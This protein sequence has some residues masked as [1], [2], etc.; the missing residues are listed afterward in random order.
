M[1]APDAS[2]W[3]IATQF[4]P[5][6]ALYFQGNR[7]TAAI[8]FRLQLA[9]FLATKK[10]EPDARLKLILFD[11]ILIVASHPRRVGKAYFSSV[12]PA[13]ADRGGAPEFQERKG[14]HGNDRDR[15]DQ[16]QS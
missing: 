1:R 13:L 11:C 4:A 8:S 7:C 3:R 14:A 2:R 12:A 5:V 10:S 9:L 6:S 16:I 15:R